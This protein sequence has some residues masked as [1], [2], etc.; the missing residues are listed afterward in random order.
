MVYADIVRQNCAAKRPKSDMFIGRLR[1]LC[2]TCR[3]APLNFH[4]YQSHKMVD[5]QAEPA[6]QVI[7]PKKLSLIAHRFCQCEERAWFCS[8]CRH[9]LSQEDS[10]Y[11]R[12]WIWRTRYGAS[13]GIGLG[14]GIGEGCQGVKCG[15]GKDCLVAQSIEVE[16]DCDVDD[17]ANYYLQQ[18]EDDLKQSETAYGTSPPPDDL[19]A[20]SPDEDFD[21]HLHD[22]EP[23]YLRQEI[24]GIGGVVKQKVKKRVMVGACVDCEVGKYL[25]HES[26]GH[27]RS[28]CGWCSKIV[29]SQQDW[30]VGI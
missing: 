12:V 20:S 15:R 14:T 17:Q 16:V 4:L 1:R 3:T 5:F 28:W 29:P 9:T 30:D 10:T 7:Q 25:Q 11:R 26:S 2:K 24:V 22:D 19:K 21:H 8:D 6:E 18:H 13:L 27:T 23:G